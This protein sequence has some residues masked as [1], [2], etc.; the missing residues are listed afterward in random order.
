M[1]AREWAMLLAP[2]VL[3]GGSFFFL[4]VV[5][6]E[7]SPLTIVYRRVA[8]AAVALWFFAIIDI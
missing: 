5:I 7:M 2:S 3:W 4:E 1:G 8:L 6:S